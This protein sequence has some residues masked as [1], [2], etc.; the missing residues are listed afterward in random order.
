[1]NSKVTRNIDTGTIAGIVNNIQHYC[2]EDGPG[3]RTAVFLKGC[4]L[5]CKW[6]SNP[7]S[8]YAGQE[9]AYNP[10]NCIGKAQCGLCIEACPESVIDVDPE[11]GKVRVE[12]KG[13][14]NCGKCVDICPAKALTLFG[15]RMTVDE[16]MAEVEKDGSFFLESGG[17]LTLSGGECMGQPDFAAALLSAAHDRGYNTVVETAFNV[18]F[19]NL[20]KVLPHVDLVL[21]DIKLVDSKRHKKWTGVDNKRILD[22]LR[23]AYAQFPDKNFIVRTPI[24]PG[25][26]DSEDDVRTVLDFIRPYKNVIAY[27]LL[28]YHR[29]GQPRYEYL[30]K[31]Y[32]MED[33]STPK[34]EDMNCLRRIIDEAFGREGSSHAQSFPPQMEI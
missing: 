1:M 23:R 22:N 5:A 16:V 11:R 24:V 17:G 10:N 7:E 28:P 34:E 3:I 4:S 12:F 29:L 32:E 19:A 33:F 30:G 2:T 20:E 18:P 14:T 8:L 15:Q 6:C 21:H 13:C 31:E 25:V 26:N 9:L 27:Q